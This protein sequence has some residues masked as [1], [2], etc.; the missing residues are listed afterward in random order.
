MIMVE[1]PSNIQALIKRARVHNLSDDGSLDPETRKNIRSADQ[2][3]RHLTKDE[4]IGICKISGRQPNEI[5]ILQN[6]SNNLVTEAKSE[7][8][9]EQPHLVLPGGALYPQERAAACWN[10]CWQFL[11]VINYAH[12]CNK[13]QFTHPD[14]MAALRQLYGELGVPLGGLGI[15]LERLKCKSTKEVKSRESKAQLTNIFDHLLQELNIS[16]VKT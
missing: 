6:Q 4:I 11:R 10:D 16:A 15:A 2:E 12:A 5:S 14:G 1:Y 7:L 3:K 13:V 9:T 8:L